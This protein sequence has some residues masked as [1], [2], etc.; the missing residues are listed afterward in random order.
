[1]HRTPDGAHRPRAILCATRALHTPAP[2]SDGRSCCMRVRPSHI[3]A[4]NRAR[5]RK[6]PAGEIARYV[7]QLTGARLDRMV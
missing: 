5:M 1:M 3:L 4:A 2:G 7:S 6:L